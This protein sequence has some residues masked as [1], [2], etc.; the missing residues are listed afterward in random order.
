M[1]TNFS[2]W[3]R[4]LLGLI[5]IVYGLNQFF[6]FIPSTYGQMPENTRSF[7]DAVVEYLPYLYIF[8]ILIGLFLLLN[9]WT[10]FIYI[11]LF[12]LSISFL[13][14]T[15]LNG[16]IHNMWPA[17]IVALL[18]FGLMLDHKEQYKPL[19]D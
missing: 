14:F 12:P 18:N 3:L 11:V 15:I 13:M 4:I 8:E 10:A 19:F 1:K 6:H 16:D 5:L 2:K 17:L 7:I 9:K